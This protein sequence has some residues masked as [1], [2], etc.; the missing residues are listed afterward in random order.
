M[1]ADQLSVSGLEDFDD[2]VALQLQLEDLRASIEAKKGK[3][4]EGNTNDED[5]ALEQYQAKLCGA[6]AC[7]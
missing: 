6:K 3:G 4:R 7:S 2:A 1:I 5:L